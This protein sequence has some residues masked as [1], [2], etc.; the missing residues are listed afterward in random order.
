MDMRHG[1]A[2][3]ALILNTVTS[4]SQPPTLTHLRSPTS[5]GWH[6]TAV[7]PTCGCNGEL[8]RW[9]GPLLTVLDA[10]ECHSY[11]RRTTP[12]GYA[13][14]HILVRGRGLKMH[15]RT[16]RFTAGVVQPG[17]PT[18]ESHGFSRVEKV[19]LEVRIKTIVMIL[20]RLIVSA[21]NSSRYPENR[22]D[23][24]QLISVVWYTFRGI[25]IHDTGFQFALRL[26]H[27][28]SVSS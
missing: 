1:A 12:S 13:T 22:T 6:V 2:G 11:H 5:S 28:G 24:L 25:K 16:R 10:R 3:N 21:I 20:I 26:P 8:D 4:A 14:R 18:E 17:L 15:Q 19:K 9:P 7:L 23:G 27:L